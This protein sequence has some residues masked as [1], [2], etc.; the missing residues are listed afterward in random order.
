MS[1]VRL[2]AP[3][4]FA[5]SYYLRRIDW[6]LVFLAALGCYLLP[7]LLIGTISMS[8]FK[9]SGEA[10]PGASTLLLLLFVLPP[11]FSGW[12][13]AR[14]AK[15]LPKLQVGVVGLLGTGYSLIV[16]SNTFGTALAL[17]ALMFAL[18]CLGAFVRLRWR[19]SDDA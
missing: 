17:A 12:F 19:R 9:E 6:P 8:L 18:V 16:R 5:M 3:L 2:L 1:S 13:T 7:S 11:I 4:Q 15:E 14:L 10:A